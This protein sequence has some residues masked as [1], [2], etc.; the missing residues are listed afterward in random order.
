MTPRNEYSESVIPVFRV[1][2][3]HTAEGYRISCGIRFH[4]G[5]SP[6]S[7]FISRIRSSFKPHKRLS[8]VVLGE[9]IYS[10]KLPLTNVRCGSGVA[11]HFAMR[12]LR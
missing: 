10:S 5:C 2:R 4:K 3:E 7:Q 8:G 6:H 11:A 9:T 12:Q 1:A